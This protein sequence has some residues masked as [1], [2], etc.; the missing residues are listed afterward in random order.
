MSALVNKIKSFVGF[1]HG[2]ID[3]DDELFD[4]LY[5][6]EADYMAQ[7]EDLYRPE[8]RNGLK[9]LRHPNA[10]GYEVCVVEPRAF[11]EALEIVNNLRNKKTVVL[12]MH[13]LDNEQCQR[14]IDFL[15]GATHALDGHQ[16]KIGNGVFI[17]A[18]NN[19]AISAEAERVRSLTDAFWNQAH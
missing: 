1:G 7:G 16:Q 4:E 19:V 17:F 11:D 14:I 3:E 15:S 2:V 12:N 13:L 8:P 18:P 10:R 9:L 6:Q 5:R